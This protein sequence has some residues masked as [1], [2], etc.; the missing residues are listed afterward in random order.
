MKLNSILFA[1]AAIVLFAS[2]KKTLADAV[3]DRFG[4]ETPAKQYV[5]HLIA[6][7]SHNSDKTAYRT[8]NIPEMKFMVRFDN[9][10]VY[11]TVNAN[12]QGD[13]NKL[14]GFSDNDQDHHTNSA[15]IGWRWYNNQLQLFAYVYNNTVQSDKLITAVAL[16]QDINC[17]IRVAGNSYVFTVNGSQVTMPRAATTPQAVGYQ[18]YPYFGGD[19]VAPQAI[20]I[21]IKDL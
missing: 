2:C 11:T 1:A 18:L 20:R 5:D 10:A 12:N 8:I 6:Q 3:K 14:Y 17:S 7:G 13:I 15:R 19:E 9:T 16:N 4:N 21:Q